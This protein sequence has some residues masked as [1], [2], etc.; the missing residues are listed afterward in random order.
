M[1]DLQTR[2]SFSTGV[3]E[4]VRDNGGSSPSVLDDLLGGR[5]FCLK[6]SSIV[7]VIKESTKVVAGGRERFKICRTRA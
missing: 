5:S 6:K 1:I 7:S 2:I 3:G 4:P